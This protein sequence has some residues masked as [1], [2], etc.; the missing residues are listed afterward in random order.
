MLNNKEYLYFPKDSI[1][2]CDYNKTGKMKEE[3][4]GIAIWV[5]IGTKSKMYSILDVNKCQKSVYKDIV[6]ILHLMNLWMFTL[7]KRSLDIL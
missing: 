1:Y 2:F 3:Y 7:I 4:G 5:F 6:L